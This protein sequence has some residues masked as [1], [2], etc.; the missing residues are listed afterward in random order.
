MAYLEKIFLDFFKGNFISKLTSHR[1][2]YAY[3]TEETFLQDFLVITRKS[4]KDVSVILI[5]VYVW[6]NYS[7]EIFSPIRTG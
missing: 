4:W 5:V 3:S 2:H 1:H 6:V 7:M